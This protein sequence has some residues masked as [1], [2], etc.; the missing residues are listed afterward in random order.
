VSVVFSFQKFK[1]GGSARN[2]MVLAKNEKNI[3]IIRLQISLKIKGFEEKSR[4][5]ISFLMHISVEC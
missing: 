2:L 5:F 3:N 4:N 1:W